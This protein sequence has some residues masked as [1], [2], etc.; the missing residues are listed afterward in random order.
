LIY[1]D[2]I[3][4]FQEKV[5]TRFCKVCLAANAQAYAE[6]FLEDCILHT[7]RLVPKEAA[8]STSFPFQDA[9][10][11]APPVQWRHKEDTAEHPP[12]SGNLRRVSFTTAD[13]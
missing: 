5:F 13:G 9:V 6:Y 10:F 4:C 12:N 11:L 3:E 2:H 8:G 1:I 7:C